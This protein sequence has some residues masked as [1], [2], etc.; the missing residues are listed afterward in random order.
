[1]GPHP[2]RR[3]FLAAGGTALAAIALVDALASPVSALGSGCS[4]G[5]CAT[6]TAWV[7][8]SDWATPR[9]P[10]GKTRLVSNAS[11]AAATNR[12]ARSEAEALDMNLHVCSWAPAVSIGVC[13]T[14]LETAF[15]SFGREWQNPW[16]GA[17]VTVIDR[18]WLPADFDLSVCPASAETSRPGSTQISGEREAVGPGPSSARS[19]AITG[20]STRRLL[21]TGIAATLTGGA[22]WRISRSGG[23]DG[24]TDTAS[25]SPAA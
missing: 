16:N 6:G 19:L 11:R 21:F 23:H 20:S 2:N 25:D 15:A 12:L 10:H 13:P 8:Q 17:R 18:R 9:G 22:A 1:M 4:G 7:L 24:E 5:S 14:Q 3:Q